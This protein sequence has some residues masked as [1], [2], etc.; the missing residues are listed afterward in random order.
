MTVG[1]RFW[2]KVQK[3]P[4]C[5]LWIA[6]RTASGYGQ[7]YFRGRM[8]IA[9]RVVWWLTTGR[10]P[11]KQVLHRCD[12][13]ICV[14]FSHLFLGTQSDNIKDAVRKGRHN[15]ARAA[16]NGNAK[17][18]WEI[19][20]EIRHQRANGVEHAVLAAKHGVHASTI[21]RICGFKTWKG[22]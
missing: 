22:R 20:N 18:G 5:W 2:S 1:E 6:S 8:E 14:R 12:V 19:V 10:W 21:S 17:F 4:T 7:F 11:K 13:Q 16:D 9:S 15:P 3:T